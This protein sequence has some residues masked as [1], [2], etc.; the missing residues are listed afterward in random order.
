MTLVG[1]GCIHPGGGGGNDGK[2]RVGNTVATGFNNFD[3]ISK[4]ASGAVL[5]FGDSGGPAYIDGKLVAVASKGDI[6]TT[7][8][9]TRLDAPESQSFLAST[10]KEAGVEICG[11]NADCED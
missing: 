1:F 3:V 9:H 5:C 10:A 8:Y 11:I 7:N 2:L 4:K 6:W